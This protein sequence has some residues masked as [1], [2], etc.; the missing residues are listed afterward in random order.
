MTFNKF[1]SQNNISLSKNSIDICIEAI[2]IMEKSIDPVHDENHIFRILKSLNNFLKNNQEFDCKKINFEVLI[3]AIFW[4]DVWKSQK[5]P[6]NAF[7]LIFNDFWEGIGSMRI[8]NKYAKESS[9]SKSI[10]SQIKYAIRTH[11]SFQIL[12]RKTLEAKLLLDFDLLDQWS[13]ERLKVLKKALSSQKKINPLLLHVFL[14]YF[15]K[16]MLPKTKSRLYFLWSKQEFEKRKDIFTKEV[17]RMEKIYKE[18]FKQQKLE[19]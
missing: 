13:V 12:P 2:K 11:P 6:H 1:L 10:V 8:F 9:L 3:V 7:A 19:T 4:H 18:Y 15:K 17:E 14:F 5:F 16:F